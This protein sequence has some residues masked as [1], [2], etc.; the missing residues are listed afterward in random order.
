MHIILHKD[1]TIPIV[2]VSVLY[3]VG[4]KNEDPSRTGFAHFFE[5]LLF[6]GSEN[7]QRGEFDKYLQNAG[8]TNNANTSNDRTFYYEVLPSNQLELG[9]WM[10]S[11]RMLNAKIEKIGV[12]TQREVVKEEKR[13]RMDNQP[14]GSILTE[15]LKH[16]YSASIPMGTYRIV[17]SF[18]CCFIG[19]VYR[20]L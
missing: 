6:E 11:E 9:L 2:A 14:Y 15:V 12:E 1:N 20:I 3:H 18:E 16:A 5:H 10:E 19:R 4:S 13:E 8:A 17:G 7:I